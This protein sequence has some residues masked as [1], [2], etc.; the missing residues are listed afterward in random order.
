M[1]R[2]KRVNYFLTFLWKATSACLP[3]RDQEESGEGEEIAEK[4]KRTCQANTYKKDW[5]ERSTRK[6][7]FFIFPHGLCYIT[8]SKIREWLE[9]GLSM[10]LS[11]RHCHSIP[12]HNMLRLSY[13]DT[14]AMQM[15]GLEPDMCMLLG[16]GEGFGLTFM[17]KTVS[18]PSPFPCHA[19]AAMLT[20]TPCWDQMLGSSNFH[21]K[22]WY[23]VV[24]INYRPKIKKIHY[25][26]IVL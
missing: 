10:W 1:K 16:P 25:M 7:F 14:V 19:L 23:K 26:K 15:L 6:I 8:A 2:N 3:Q 20:K 21:S 9:N 4:R 5:I 12:W 13:F 18:S 22:F 17:V 11:I 24:K